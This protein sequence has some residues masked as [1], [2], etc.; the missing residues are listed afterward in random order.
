V[1]LVPSAALLQVPP[2]HV[3][4]SGQEAVQVPPQPS[5]APPHLRVQLG[6]QQ[7]LLWQTWPLPQTWV[8]VPQCV[9]SV[10]VLTSHPSFPSV[11]QWA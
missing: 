7:L 2:L 9:A 11:L 10:W 4:H 3:W 8:H 1:Q 5:L 6:V